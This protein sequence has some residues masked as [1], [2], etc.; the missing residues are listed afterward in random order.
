M[1]RVYAGGQT[2]D[3]QLDKNRWEAEREK[4]AQR[5]LEAIA[6]THGVARIPEDKRDEDP[7]QFDS[8]AKLPLV[9]VLLDPEEAGIL[10]PSGKEIYL[11]FVRSL[12]DGHEKLMYQLRPSLAIPSGR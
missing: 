11:W 2:P 1:G 6:A 8:G 12:Q 7:Q 5:L 9:E 3:G 4:E 10:G